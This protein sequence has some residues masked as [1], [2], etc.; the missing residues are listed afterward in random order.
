MVWQVIKIRVLQWLKRIIL[1][2]TYGTLIFFAVGFG[3]LQIPSVQ[4]AL[5]S[6]ITDRFSNVSGFT[7]EY[8]R[9]Y[10]LWY[11]RLEITSLKITD[12]QQN[13]LIQAGRLF[14]NFRISSLYARNNIYLDA[15]SLQE[16]GVNL[17]TIPTSDSTKELNI[18]VFI[19]EIGRQLSSGESS[20]GGGGAKIHIGEVLIQ[21]SQ[22]S[23]SNTD[24]D[25]LERGFDPNHFRVALDDGNLNNFSVIGDTIQFAL[26]SLR[27]KESKTN[28]TISDMRTYFRISQTSMEFLGLDLICNQ[29]HVSDTIILNYSS[30]RDL[31]D[32]NQRVTIDAR[33]K[34]TRIHPEDISHFARGLETWK[35]TITLNGHFKGKISRFAFRPMQIA[36][37]RT[38][39]SGSLEMDG[40]PSVDETFINAKLNP[41]TAYGTDLSFLFPEYINNTII[42]LGR[43]QLQ[44]TFT[45][46]TN[47][48]VANGDFDTNLGHIASDINYKIQEGNVGLSSYRGNISLTGFHLGHFFRD[49]VN[50]Q[51]VNLRG[52]INGKGF[53]K[54]NADFV[55]NGEVSSIGIRGYN[56]VNIKSNARFANQFFEGSLNID[57]P[58]LQFGMAGSIDLREG[59]DIIKVKARLDTAIFEN[60]KLTRR[61]F[62]LQSMIDIDS[63]GLELDSIVGNAIF[64]KVVMQFED[65][66]LRMDSVHLISETHQDGRALTLRSSIADLTLTGDFY[67]STMFNDIQ[68]L[69]NEF[70]LNLRNDPVAIKAYYAAKPLTDQAYKARIN[71][72]VHNANPLL[73]MLD[74]DLFVSPETLIQG[75]FSN[76]TTSRLHVY[77]H[78][79]SVV[80][81]GKEFMDNEIE[82]HGSKVRDS[83]QVLAQLTV[84]SQ[85]QQLSP[86]V[87]T[88]DLFAE[89]IWNLDHIDLNLDVEQVGYSNLL[90]LNAEIDFLEDSTKIKILPSTIRMLGNDWETNGSNYTLVKG[91]EWRLHQV[92]FSRENQSIKIDGE[93]SRDS[94]KALTIDIRNVNMAIFNFFSKEK[95]SGRLNATIIQ[96]DLYDDLFIENVLQIDSLMVNKFLVGE[97]NGNNTL[98]PMTGHFNINLTVDR[99]KMRMVDV[100]GYYDPGNKESPLKAKA[101]LA[102]ADIRLIEPVVRDL[103]SQLEGTLTGEYN[104]NGTFSQPNISGEAHL[105]NGQLMVNYLKTL[106]KVNGTVAMTPSQIQFRNFELTDIFKNTGKLHGY[107]AHRNFS[108]MAVSLDATFSNFHLLNTTI[109]DNDLFYGQAFGSGVLSI[110]G[111][112]NNIKISATAATNKN[113]RLALPLGGGSNSQEKKE[114]IQFVSFSQHLNTPKKQVT[115]AKRELSGLTLDLNIDVTPDAYTEIIFDIKS[116]DIIRG[117]GRGDIRLQVDTK[118]EFNM[119][120]RIDFTEGAYNFTLY[121]II[122][123]EFQIKPGSSIAWYGDPYEGNLN[124]TASYRQITSMAPV[125]QD[126]SVVNDPAIRRKYPVEVLLK[127]EGLMLSPTLTFDLSARDLPDNV[128]TTDGKSVRLRF[129]FEAFKTKLDESELKLQ[130]FSLII[131]RK[132][133]PPNAFATNASTVYN[134]VSE[135]L[136]NQLSYWLSQVDENL[137][138]DLDLGTLDQEAFNTFQLRLSYSFLNGR[139]R[140]SKD[141]SFGGN[142]TNRSDLATIAGD[143]TVDYLLTPDGKFKVKMYSRSNVNQLQ[144][145]LNTQTAA[146]TTG[147]SLLYT[148]NFNE[149]SDLLRS[150]RERRKR[151]LE[152]NP[153]SGDDDIKGNNP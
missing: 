65:E 23:L 38:I 85:R 72:K 106:Y 6:R 42:P 131:L 124:I 8:D 133:S 126:Q 68:K 66:S 46:F 39:I 132:L 134:S 31:S 53:S 129:E 1:Y 18:D 30:Q 60:L 32:F 117:R 81:A 12:P 97:V 96:K 20:G 11:D 135:L 28:L 99:M 115:P 82:F 70:V 105:S 130:V 14:V 141:G 111:P 142:Q 153:S 128:I 3:V 103:F 34:N 127:L 80:Y 56:Y 29:S 64:R 92:G 26:T 98:D 102:K 119:F 9:F 118:G 138:I 61:K 112:I 149:F 121:D 17:V 19:A 150:A 78:L 84:T 52:N 44:G 13:T 152:R 87:L 43:M 59:R 63:R 75:E 55:L 51:E 136:S 140:V 139:L 83:T 88:R 94:T 86:Q 89:G 40:L 16:G 114:F 7:I 146:V 21:Q 62:F 41:S 107:I 91:R 144:S 15:V 71:M 122:N 100:K 101:I 95:F 50:F 49:T 93:I 69:V 109:K 10:L 104:I 116:G 4:K 147:T 77:S 113:T 137:E 48:F 5:L 47:D 2:G 108:R 143:W 37:G 73:G 123:K 67:Y 36:V 24:A 76:S 54:S 74:V 145:S 22:F 120:G 33:L 58:N 148:E 25:S 110:L 27:I 79:D 35:Q 45:G 57:D 151:E 125:L 90:R